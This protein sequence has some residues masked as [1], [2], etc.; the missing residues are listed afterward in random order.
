[1]TDKRK[2]RWTTSRCFCYPCFPSPQECW[3]YKRDPIPEPEL[4]PQAWGESATHWDIP[5]FHSLN[6]SCRGWRAST[7]ITSTCC[8]SKGVDLISSTHMAAST[9]QELWAQSKSDALFW[10]TW[11]LHVCDTQAKYPYTKIIFFKIKKSFNGHLKR[12]IYAYVCGIV[13]IC[14]VCMQVPVG[15]IEYW[16]P[17]A[18]L[19][20]E[21]W[22]NMFSF[23]KISCRHDESNIQNLSDRG[24]VV[25]KQLVTRQW[26]KT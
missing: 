9:S 16:I 17:A 2:N 14:T 4:D 1:M 21:H 7:A 5:T 6:N 24:T 20:P 3:G 11:A 18:I 10:P 13:F 26:S 23:S 8:S 22:T 19:L 25:W 15:A 12:F